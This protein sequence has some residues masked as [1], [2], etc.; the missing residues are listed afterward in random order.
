[1]NSIKNKKIMTIITFS[2][3]IIIISFAYIQRENYM[4]KSISK[5]LP[6]N[7][8]NII[9]PFLQ[10]DSNAFYNYGLQIPYPCFTISRPPIFPIFTRTIL[11]CFGDMSATTV[12]QLKAL[13]DK[14]DK[15]YFA[16]EAEKVFLNHTILR[17]S[18][19]LLNLS[20]ITLMFLFVYWFAGKISALLFA[21]LWST[22]LSSIFYSVLYLRVDMM[23]IF[24]LLIL[25]L[26]LILL[27]SDKYKWLV[28]VGIILLCSVA[29]LTRLS[30]LT[31]S[32]L[33]IIL[34]NLVKVIY[35]KYHFKDM[36]T[37][38]VILIG[39][40]ILV[41]PYLIYNYNRTKTVAPVMNHHAKFW[42]NH[43]FAGKPGYPTVAEVANDPYC[44]DET[45]SFKY[46]FQDHSFIEVIAQYAK[47]YW[48]NFTKYLPEM[49][50]FYF[51][52]T[53]Y[54]LAWLLIFIFPGIY[55]CLKKQE[56]GLM[57]LIFSLIVL[58][59]FSFILS[60][61][62]IFSSDHVKNIIG[63]EPRF[64]MSILPY[65][66]MMCAIGIDKTLCLSMKYLKKR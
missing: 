4:F 23:T 12:A 60:L 51:N 24:N 66:F 58:F 30:A 59:P 36:W 61:N 7:Q 33:V 52:G 53:K 43:E 40:A 42:R 8:L 1:M 50:S 27:K 18:S 19:I 28:V 5:N 32:F 14:L 41:S 46:V 57:I 63:V 35:K 47:G 11:K 29:S 65:A 3:F 25:C 17:E 20:A 49:F 54:N 22:N 45:T 31:T 10:A 64:N 48:F 37:G 34:F 56:I 55:Y 16:K 9:T 15:N 21:L 44:G 39:I 62:E 6:N 38:L 13:K 2:L 26:F